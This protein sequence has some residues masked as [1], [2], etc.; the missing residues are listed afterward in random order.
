MFGASADRIGN[1]TNFCSLIELLHELKNS[2]VNIEAFRHLMSQQGKRKTKSLLDLYTQ[3]KIESF[4][5]YF[6]RILNSCVV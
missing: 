5:A 2:F 1:I 4:L 3:Q 6:M